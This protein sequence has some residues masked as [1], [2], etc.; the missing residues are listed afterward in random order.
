MPKQ[1]DGLFL[2][3]DSQARCWWCQ[4]SLEYRDYHDVEWGRP[5]AD[6]DRLFEKICLEGFQ[7]GLSW[8]TILRKRDEFRTAFDKF[9][10]HKVAK[11]TDKRVSKLLQNKGIVRHKGKIEATIN[12]AARAIEME[13][14]FG[15]LAAWFWQH[16]PKQNRSP[17]KT[18][19]DAC[20]R[21]TC[22]EAEQMSKA[23]KKRGWKFVGPTTAYAFMQA[24][25]MVNDHLLGCRSFRAVEKLREDFERPVV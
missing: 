23:L 7:S 11:F 6:D 17:F 3:K 12:N 10:F 24:M 5:T 18:K 16:E 1:P 21:T 9:D 22:E 15:S 14:E 20:F 4:G 13:N 2:D 8:L 25:G 19:A